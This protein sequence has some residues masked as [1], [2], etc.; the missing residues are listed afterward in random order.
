MRYSASSSL[1]SRHRSS[2]KA[3][4][5]ARRPSA[6]DHQLTDAVLGAVAQGVDSSLVGGDERSPLVGG[7]R[8]VVAVIRPGHRRD[9]TGLI[10]SVA[11]RAE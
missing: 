3:D 11:D 8:G 6:G 9:A 4:E 2:G 1:R 7:E 10:R 5:P